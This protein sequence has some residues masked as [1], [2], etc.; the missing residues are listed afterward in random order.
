MRGNR[1]RGSQG[2]RRARKHGSSEALEAGQI[3]VQ[4][5]RRCTP[6]EV[7]DDDPMATL[8]WRAARGLCTCRSTADEDHG[9]PGQGGVARGEPLLAT[10][11]RAAAATELRAMSVQIEGGRCEGGENEEI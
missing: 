8:Q 4:I 3:E 2:S 5:D 11:A 9:A 7:E 1:G 6:T 10:A